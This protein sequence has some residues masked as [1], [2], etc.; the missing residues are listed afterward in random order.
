[1]F[2]LQG[3]RSLCLLFKYFARAEWRRERE[4]VF[5]F[6]SI[7]LEK[8]VL[9][10]KSLLNLLL[11]SPFEQIYRK[12]QLVHITDR[13]WMSMPNLIKIRETATLPGKKHSHAH[14]ILI[15]EPN[16]NSL[17]ESNHLLP[18]TSTNIGSIVVLNSTYI[19]VI[20]QRKPT[21][22]HT[23]TQKTRKRIKM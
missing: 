8:Y 14:D 4:C 12:R 18:D 13:I 19:C 20:M 11:T 7:S 10:S 23:K 6:L 1:M 22:R 17:Q 16:P 9:N 5:V 15:L 21:D 3:S 2:R